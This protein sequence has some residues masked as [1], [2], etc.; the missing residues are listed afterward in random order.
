MD[1]FSVSVR[2]QSKRIVQ[3]ANSSSSVASCLANVETHRLNREFLPTSITTDGAAGKERLAASPDR[4]AFV[5]SKEHQDGIVP[6]VVNAAANK[7]VSADA[8]EV[9]YPGGAAGRALYSCVRECLLAP[10]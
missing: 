10:T 6:A 5:L 8:M 1:R 3:P 9:D 4:P 2:D 7:S